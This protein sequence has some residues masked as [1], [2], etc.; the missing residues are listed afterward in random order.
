[1]HT[2]YKIAR[3]SNQLIN[4]DS[5]IQY[6]HDKERNLGTPKG[7]RSVFEIQN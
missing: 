4:Q 5:E 1:M 3:E 2:E 7:R 6:G